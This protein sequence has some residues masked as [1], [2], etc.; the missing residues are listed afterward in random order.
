MFPN[1]RR[2]VRIGSVA[3]S[4]KLILAVGST[5]RPRYRGLLL[6]LLKPFIRNGDLAIHYRCYGQVN[7]SSL[8]MSDLDSDV[9]STLELGVSD[10]YRLE[11]D[12]QPDV[13]I[14]GGG[15]IGLFTLRAAAACNGHRD[16]TR[17]VVCE[18]LPRNIP[19]IEKH[20][21]MNGIQADLRPCCLGG[22][23]RTIPFYCRGAHESSFDG[24]TPY[25]SVM[26]IPVI[27]LHDLIDSAA[28]R[29]L[30]KLDIEGMEMETLAAYLPTEQ[31]PVYLVGELHNRQTNAPVLEELFRT[32]GWT[33]ELFHMGDT[34]CNFRGCSPAAVGMLHWA[35]SLGSA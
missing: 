15:N 20:L 5:T 4:Y 11:P 14:D 9:M 23:H 19:Q 35:R 34:A 18:P 12:F 2:I 7:R 22:S 6:A 33:L 21:Q 30:I 32:H 3:N 16:S 13:V 10:F 8:R 17:F 1:I 29:I 28:E 27:T 31:R 26:E 24:S 25:E